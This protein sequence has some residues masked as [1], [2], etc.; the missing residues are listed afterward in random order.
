[1]VTRKVLSVALL[2]AG[3]AGAPGAARAMHAT[4]ATTWGLRG[5]GDGFTYALGASAGQLDGTASELVFDYPRGRRFKLSELTWDLKGVVV[6]GVQASAGVGDRFT[7]NAGLWK[8]VNE[9]DGMM[10]DRDWMYVNAIE[11]GY[12]DHDD[13]TDDDWTHESRHPDTTVDDGTMLDLNLSILAWERGAFKAS[14][15]VGF[16]WDWWSWSARGGTYV[17]SR[18]EFRDTRGEFRNPDGTTP[19]VIEYEQR[20]SIP[21]L[22]VALAWERPS[23]RVSAHARASA[24]VQASDWDYHALRDLSFEGEFGGGTY[25][26]AG[27]EAT[28]LFTRRWY[29]T[30]AAQHQTI[31]E[32]VGDVA[33]KAPGESA[34]FQRGGGVALKATMVTLGVGCRF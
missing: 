25:L 28:W 7:V 14:G 9:G 21:Y 29:A 33:V 16:M 2:A 17:Y 30:L 10:V 24:A 19:L 11:M 31:G 8:P 18:N 6:A 5:Q 22:G 34:T 12:V 26:G 32:T 3:I 4:T 27:I 13:I 1:M 23:W 15:L 20:Y